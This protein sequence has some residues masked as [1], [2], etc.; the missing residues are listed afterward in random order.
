[1]LNRKNGKCSICFSHQDVKQAVEDALLTGESGMRIA[2]RLTTEDGEQMF[3][4]SSVYRHRYKCMGMHGFF[5]TAAK[6]RLQRKRMKA[7]GPQQGG[8][9]IIS[10]PDSWPGDVPLTQSRFTDAHGNE[11]HIANRS[12][13]DI[14]L[15][16]VFEEMPK[17]VKNPYAAVHAA[18]EEALAENAARDALTNSPQPEKI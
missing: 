2:K 6:L 16:V 11:F 9:V 17:K 1:M 7:A 5:D 13:A 3:S 8:R 10:W 4:Q 18:H 15:R 12:K 14:V